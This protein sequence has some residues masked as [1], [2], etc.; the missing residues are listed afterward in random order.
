MRT[1]GFAALIYVLAGFSTALSQQGVYGGVAPGGENPPPKAESIPKGAVMVTWPG[2]QM[3]EEGGSRFFLQTSRPVKYETKKSPG[4]FVLVLKNVRVHLK[5]NWRPLETE[6]FDT[7]VLRA[8]VERRG[9]RNVAMVFELRDDVTPSIK[10]E[11]G[12]DGYAYI[13]IDF[14][15]T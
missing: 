9:R 3:L 12:K 4:K 15:P 11:K 7:P 8:T 14:E 5:N 13:M 6:F 1:I 10:R 2:F